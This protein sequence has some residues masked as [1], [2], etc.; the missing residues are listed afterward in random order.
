MTTSK[1]PKT[2]NDNDDFETVKRYLLDCPHVTSGHPAIKSALAGIEKEQARIARDAKL[3]RKFAGGTTTAATG[4]T[5]T[6]GGAA[7]TNNKGS[8]NNLSETMVVID[9]DSAAPSPTNESS[10]DNE[11]L[12]WQDVASAKS[13]EDDLEGSGT[14]SDGSS[15]LGKEM[16]KVAIESIAQHQIKVRSPLAAI[17]AVL[18][19]SLRS[20]ALGFS[21]TG[22]PED[23]SKSNGFAAP[24]RE[25]PKAV[26]LPPNWDSDPNNISL[27]YR[28]DGTGATV[29]AVQ[30]Q[31]NADGRVK[32]SFQPATN[33]EP[34]SVSLSFPMED[35]INLDSWNAAQKVSAVVSPALHYKALAVLLSNFVRTFDLGAVDEMGK[36]ERAAPYV[37]NTVLPTPNP[38]T[39]GQP[40]IIK[41]DFVPGH[42]PGIA[43][44]DN[45]RKKPW[46]DGV[47]ATL[48]QAF[49]SG[50]PVPHGDFH[51]D[52]V[53]GG[54]LQDPR[55]APRAPGGGLTGI[56]GNLMGPNHPM[57]SGGGIN[58]P[59]S[60][61][62]VGGPGSMQPRF[63]PVL[64][65]GVDVDIDGRPRRQSRP[66][67][68][69]APNPDHLP[70]PNSFGGND[71]M[72]M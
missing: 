49:P 19:A 26:F 14:N 25:L 41:S 7:S 30:L 34:S 47:P 22:I 53:P 72:Y 11:M 38:S 5:A 40:Q 37:D 16:S 58:G 60:V 33:K 31:A 57:F 59:D 2:A 42:V 15:F 28:K 54:G 29:L 71:H 1:K 20:E 35:H 68:T 27:R 65:P 48:E 56:P 45:R 52:L 61:G 17:A 23:N 4:A 6:T 21:C 63:D 46:Q 66:S 64:P 44:E 55:F 8:N 62:P 9:K 24:V 13:K 36:A 39:A 10:S 70:P 3:Q 69:G 51:G 43:V 12:E 32:V 18:H 67:R 50:H